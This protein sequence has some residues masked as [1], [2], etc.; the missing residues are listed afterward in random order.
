MHT[1]FQ[2]ITVPLIV[3]VQ[4]DGARRMSCRRN[5]QADEECMIVIYHKPT[6]HQARLQFWISLKMFAGAMCRGI[7]DYFRRVNRMNDAVNRVY[8]K[9][10]KTDR[11]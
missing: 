7:G 1:R 2:K 3:D 4:E 11:S 6:I 8:T 10:K 9:Q 5:V